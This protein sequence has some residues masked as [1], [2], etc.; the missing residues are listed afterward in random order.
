M[1]TFTQLSCHERREIYRGLCSRKS[2]NEIARSLTRNPSTITR[3][4]RRNSDQHGYLYPEDAHKKALERKHKNEAK[5]NKFDDLRIFVIENLKSR[6]SPKSIAGRWNIESNERKISPEAIYQW[7]YTDSEASAG[8]KK[9]LIRARKKRGLARKQS[10]S[11]IKNR[12]SIHDRP[13]AINQR[14]EPG[15]YEC[16]LIFNKGSQS[17]NICTLIERVSRFALLIHNENKLTKTVIDRLIEEILQFKLVVKS[18]TFDNGS[19]F[20]DH[21]KLNALGIVT[22]FC[23]PGA[24][25]Q[26]GGIE[27]FNGFV[28]RFFPFK[29]SAAEIF[30]AHVKSINLKVN[31]IP[32]AIL[33]YKTPIEAMDSHFRGVNLMESRVKAALPAA[34]AVIFN[35]N[36]QGIA[37]HV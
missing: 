7:I 24:P 31:A 10:Q 3:E 4:V 20:A 32:R 26:K 37:F 14:S 34:E 19:E 1:R 21:H 12:V 25:W 11:K 29:L 35:Q 18:I 9:E 22:Y 8:L 23:D 30:P 6:W 17:K 5:L 28:R 33:G 13:E 36:N 16:D 27:N 15:H 2:K